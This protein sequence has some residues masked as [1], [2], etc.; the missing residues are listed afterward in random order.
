MLSM[1]N[2]KPEGLNSDE[3]ATSISNLGKVRP[4]LDQRLWKYADAIH[5]FGTTVRSV[6]NQSFRS[7]TEQQKAFV[8]IMDKAQAADALFDKLRA[9]KAF[10]EEL[11]GK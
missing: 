3:L 2:G 5:D 11:E 6:R 7:A 8:R 9:D 4:L 1:K 10:M